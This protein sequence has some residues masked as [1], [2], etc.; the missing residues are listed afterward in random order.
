MCISLSETV[1][2]GMVVYQPS[3]VTTQIG[4]DRL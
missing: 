3:I 2:E 4:L 1:F